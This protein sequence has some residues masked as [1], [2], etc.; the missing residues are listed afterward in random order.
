MFDTLF[1]VC[2]LSE[3]SFDRDAM[4]LGQVEVKQS[5]IGPFTHIG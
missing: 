1:L 3:A 4:T 5:E 2:Q